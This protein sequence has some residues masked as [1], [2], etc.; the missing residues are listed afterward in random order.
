[1]ASTESATVEDHASTPPASGGAAKS[2]TGELTAAPEL[3]PSSHETDEPRRAPRRRG[4]GGSTRAAKTPRSER[5]KREPLFAPARRPGRRVTRIVRHVQLWSVFKIA[6]LGG[7]VFYAVF[8]TFVGV[9]WSLANATGQIHHIEQFMRQIGFDNWSFNGPQLFRA[10]ALV[11][12]IVLVAGSILITLSAAVMNVISEA[13]G[14]IRFTVI[15]TDESDDDE[16]ESDDD[17]GR[18][19]KR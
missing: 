14:G 2:S 18:R 19:R 13:T 10:A 6:L 7:L 12:A 9:S 17:R 15:E 3:P 1:M 16:D 5:A 8:L 4:S 11:G